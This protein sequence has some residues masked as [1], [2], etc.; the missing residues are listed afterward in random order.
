ML[1]P[2]ADQCRHTMMAMFTFVFLFCFVFLYVLFYGPKRKSD[3]S[4]VFVSDI[5][6]F[7]A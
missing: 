2:A 3:F 7:T 4:D 1:N 5:L 6:M